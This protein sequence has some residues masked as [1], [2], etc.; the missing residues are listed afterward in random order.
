MLSSHSAAS[1]PHK[2]ATRKSKFIT[3]ARDDAISIFNAFGEIFG[4]EMFRANSNF[5]WLT[6]LDPE[7]YDAIDQYVGLKIVVDHLN[8]ENSDD[9]RVAALRDRLEN[10]FG[11][12]DKPFNV[13]LYGFC[14][15]VC[16]AMLH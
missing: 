9:D 11:A 14:F 7:G 3:V 5:K 2:R 12:L 16:P 1:A 6:W 13:R 8:A 10:M 15:T 4:L